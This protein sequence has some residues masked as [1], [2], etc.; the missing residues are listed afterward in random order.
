MDDL[1]AFIA[2]QCNRSPEFRTEY[3]HGG[4]PWRDRLLDR[5]AF[6]LMWPAAQWDSWRWQ[7]DEPAYIHYWCD[8]WRP[9]RYV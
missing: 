1:D 7:M 3:L 9:A 8:G 4:R 5:L 2:Q 6:A